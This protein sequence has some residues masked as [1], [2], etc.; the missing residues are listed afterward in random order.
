MKKLIISFTL[1]C[2]FFNPSYLIKASTEKKFSIDEATAVYSTT[3]K[4]D[5]L[6]LM[7]SYPEYIS[8]VENNENGNVYLVLKSGKKLLYDD[9]KIKSPSEKLS[10]PDLQ[11]M[12]EQIYPLSPITNVMEENFDPGRSRVYELLKETY[13]S[14][15]Q[16]IEGNLKNVNW[17]YGSCQF[18]GNNNAALSLY[19][20]MK[21]LVTLSQRNNQIKNCV[22]PCSGTF[23]YRIIA[24]T[25][26]LSPHS[27][28]IA[29]DLAVSKKDY[30]KWSSKSDGNKR[31]STYPPE[32]VETFERN[33]FIWGG[34][35]GH[36]DIMHF[37]YRPEII[38]KSKYFKDKPDSKNQWYDGLPL[39]NVLMK[40]T[41]D[42]INE[43]L[44]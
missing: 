19:S 23:N 9:K 12:L 4:Q 10:N 27:F 11:D 43:A 21:E 22:F 37:E 3:M 20:V 35:W 38:M 14:S 39:D 32:I 2:L 36:F 42:K 25:N 5:L 30:W 31:L 34:K 40:S 44:K 29:I 26:Q 24:G 15:K 17:G 6:C 33:N 8:H 28:G 7:M 41:I 13:G 16:S 1:V 18:N